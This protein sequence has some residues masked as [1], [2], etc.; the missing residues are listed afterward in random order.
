MQNPNHKRRL[1]VRIVIGAAAAL[2]ISAFIPGCGV[3]YVVRSAYFQ[4]ELLHSRTPIDEVRE[5]GNLS[6]KHLAA[7]DRIADVKKYGAQ[8]GLQA[9]E[10]YDTIAAEWDRTIWNMSACPSLSFQPVTW[11]FPIVGTVPYLG[12]FRREDADRWVERMEQQGHEVY[13]RTAGA[14]S[15]LVVLVNQTTPG[16]NLV[17]K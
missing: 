7:L 5:T 2:L 13:L 3:G 12:F 6:A 16:A 1:A 14:Y 15:T 17:Q 8:I 11:R 10:N 4:A 9:T